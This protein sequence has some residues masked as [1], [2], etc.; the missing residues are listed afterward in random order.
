MIKKLYFLF[1]II[2]LAHPVYSL[3]IQELLGN[4]LAQKLI[5]AREIT[6]NN[7]TGSNLR[8]VPRDA[9]LR[10]M[11]TQNIFELEPNIIVE[12]LFLYTKP[13]SANKNA[14]RGKERLSIYNEIVK[15]STLKEIRYYS[16]TRNKMHTLYEYSSIVDNTGKNPRH[17]TSFQ[18]LPAKSSFYVRKKDS[19]FGDNTYLY[20]YDISNYAF[21][22]SLKNISPLKQAMMT[23][24]EK[25]NLRLFVS[26]LDAEQY[27]LIYG[28][29]IGKGT[30][31]PG[32]KEQVNSSI[33]NR[34]IALLKWFMQK[35]DA[36]LSKV[37]GKGLTAHQNTNWV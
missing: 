32:M 14:W 24:V 36:G 3:S 1:A 6:A 8:I 16:R 11:I 33:S 26:I 28:V 15:L 23:V 35:T 18:A 19:A 10:K 9:D 20:T 34:L 17:D 30:L 22:I 37:T 21:T 2:C 31:L 13:S 4:E 25:N 5:A 12:S 7:R 27:I 29:A